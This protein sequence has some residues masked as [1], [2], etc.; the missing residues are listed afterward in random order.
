VSKAVGEAFPRN[1]PRCVWSVDVEAD[2]ELAAQRLAE[3]LAE[4]R[5]DLLRVRGARLDAQR[6]AAQ[7]SWDE[8]VAAYLRIYSEVATGRESPAM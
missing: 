8:C 1:D 5:D 2:P 6:L 7:W 3:R 4:L